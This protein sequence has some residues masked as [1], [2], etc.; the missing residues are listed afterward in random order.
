MQSKQRDQRLPSPY[1]LYW[2]EDW[3][4]T[5]DSCRNKSKYK[6]EFITARDDVARE[7]KLLTGDRYF[8]MGAAKFVVS[9]DVPLR[10]DGLPLAGQREPTDPGVAVWWVQKDQLRVMA[11]DQWR[12]VRENLRGV[13]LAVEALRAFQRCGATQILDRALQSFDRPALM[14]PR[15][16]WFGVLG[17][18]VWPPSVDD[19]RRAYNGKVHTA[20][21]DK[22]GSD[23]QFI[24]LTRAREEAEQFARRTHG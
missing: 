8:D 3:P 9:T 13:G 10:L 11:C 4:R 17:L 12:T 7:L 15:P 2:P 22:G 18:T 21:P 24:I 5:K 6:V 23:A 19:V 14:A 1:P 20:H 16:E